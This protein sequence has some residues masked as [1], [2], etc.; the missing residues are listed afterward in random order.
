MPGKA[1][2]VLFFCEGIPIILYDCHSYRSESSLERSCHGC[3]QKRIARIN[4]E[5]IAVYKD[6][7]VQLV[8]APSCSSTKKSLSSKRF[9]S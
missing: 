5:A 4:V 8:H 3:W 7:V 9:M 1:I 6:A 2:E